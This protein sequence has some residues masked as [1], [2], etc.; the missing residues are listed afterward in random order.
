MTGQLWELCLKSW[1]GSISRNATL[2][3][4]ISGHHDVATHSPV[5]SPAAQNTLNNTVPYL[6]M[7]VSIGIPVLE[8]PVVHVIGGAITNNKKSCVYRVAGASGEIVHST[9]V[10]L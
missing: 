2:V 1:E 3:V 10:V 7:H 6:Y 4:L 5:G 8:K 9:A